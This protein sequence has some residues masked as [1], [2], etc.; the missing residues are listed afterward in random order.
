M[1][2]RKR[3]PGKFFPL[4]PEMRPHGLLKTPRERHLRVL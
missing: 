3:Q 2:S 4:N 1:A